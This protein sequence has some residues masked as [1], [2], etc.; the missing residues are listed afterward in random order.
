MRQLPALTLSQLDYLVAVADSRSWAGAAATRG[1]TPSALSQG[2]AEL[3]RRLGVRLF[4][5]DGRRRTLA[6]T[7]AE[8]LA[9]ARRVLADTDDLARWLDQVRSGHAGPFRLGMIDAAALGHWPHTLQALRS[10]HESVSLQLSIGPSGQ[11]LDQLQANQLDLAVIV[12]PAEMPPGIDWTDLLRDPLAVYAPPGVVPGPPST[13][14]PWVSFPAASHTR[15]LIDEQLRRVGATVDVQS[16][17]HQPEVLKEMVRLGLGWTV[18]PVIQ[19]EGGVS[20]LIRAQPEPLLERRLVAARRNG[21]LPHP[22]TDWF[23]KQ[24]VA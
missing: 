22:L 15:R 24:L 20:P 1:V 21:R 12:A 10:E 5:R 7:A 18:L 23:I 13:W 8:V 11:L 14:G 17:S 2:L 9:Y 19:A 4:E 16:E 6:P 3:E